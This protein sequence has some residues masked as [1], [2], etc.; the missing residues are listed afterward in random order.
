MKNIKKTTCALMASAMMLSMT[1][2]SF[3]PSKN[4]PDDVIEAAEAFAE[5][6]ADCDFDEMS[7]AAS[8]DFEDDCDDWEGILDFNN[9]DLYGEKASQFISAVARTIDYEIDED[10]VEFKKDKAQVDVV[11]ALSDYQTILDEDHIFISVMLE[12]LDDV[13]EIEIETTFELEKEKGK[14]VVANY[15]DIMDDLYE[16]TT[17]E[18][19]DRIADQSEHI[20][21]IWWNGDGYESETPDHLICNFSASQCDYFDVAITTDGT[22]DDYSL[23][24]TIECN[25]QL[26]STQYTSA[27]MLGT[28]T[29]GAPLDSSGQYLE[30]GMYTITFYDGNGDVVIV[31]NANIF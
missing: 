18:L 7:D 15:E 22:I 14:W 10:S 31:L 27:V 20:N 1:G 23:Y 30:A 17:C 19:T 16:F 6:A 12:S 11:F 13:G 25:G 26:V 2:C 4:D 28:W 9:E 5:G 29:D 8:E 21:D 24:A 3:L